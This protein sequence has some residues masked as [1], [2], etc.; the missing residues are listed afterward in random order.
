MN[1]L[2]TNR[3]TGVLIRVAFVFFMTFVI[4]GCT[5]EEK[6]V[7]E[8]VTSPAAAGADIYENSLVNS[9]VSFEHELDDYVPKKT[10]YNF[11]F[12]YKL[13][14]PWWDAVAMGLEDAAE[15]FEDKGIT[16]NYE[17]LAP[18]AVDA[19]DQ[20][21]RIRSASKRGFDVIGVDVADSAVIA[22]VIN[23]VMKGGQKV[24]TFSSS[25]TAESDNCDRIAYVGNTHNYQDGA[26]LAEAL[27]A[28]IG[29]KG[30]IGII[31]GDPGAPCHEERLAGA[32]DVIKKYKDVKIIG[33]D[34]DR[35]SADRAEKIADRFIEK[36]P[37]LS[38]I[39]CC[40]M[41]NPVGAAHS[42]ISHRLTD[43]I[44]I[45]GMDH[46]ERALRL[47]H[48]GMIYCL[49]V[50]D[51]CSI[52]FDTMQVAVKVADGLKPGSEYQ[53]FTNEKTTLIYQK[54]AKAMMYKLY[55]QELK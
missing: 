40:N 17:Y 20:A 36:E 51:C 24:I 45:V 47:L 16:I 18:N 2:F 21:Q 33:V 29:Y 41:V 39:I 38:G 34:Y 43:K 15:Q 37:D 6:T 3:H 42:V 22:P 14:H 35:E 30:K 46:D 32:K 55:G 8:G 23:Q 1:R 19:K 12:T 53:K 10:E 50:Q 26:D 31:V 48:E 11:Y 7:T 28:R 49:G 13:V 5:G 4:T 9:A 44:T 27:C 52:G 54:D 25:D